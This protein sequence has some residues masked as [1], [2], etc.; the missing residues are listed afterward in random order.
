MAREELNIPINAT[1]AVDLVIALYDA[2]S[3]NA[4]EKEVQ[5]QPTKKQ[6]NH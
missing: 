5:D 4:S 1:T 3:A 6:L 2:R